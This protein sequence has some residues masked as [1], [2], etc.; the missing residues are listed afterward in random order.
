MINHL[1][2]FSDVVNLKME[3]V[4]DQI[5]NWMGAGVRVFALC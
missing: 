3:S 2:Y 4:I 5:S 1:V